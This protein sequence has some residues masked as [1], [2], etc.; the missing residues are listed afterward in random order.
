MI[1]IK[2]LPSKVT[3]DKPE[4]NN[5]YEI[6][7][8]WKV[9]KE[10]IHSVCGV[11]RRD[12]DYIKCLNE[13]IETLKT[14]I[15]KLKY[16]SLSLLL[17]DY[18]YKQLNSLNTEQQNYVLCL[19]RVYYNLE[20]QI[21]VVFYW[22]DQDNIEEDKEEINVKNNTTLGELVDYLDIHYPKEDI[23]VTMS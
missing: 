19:I 5:L 1:E 23:K 14:E 16:T 4:W 22:M 15:F 6:T 2:E 11:M 17:Y 18:K 9:L 10:F 7:H 12:N 3:W 13:E 20:K 21:N 8:R